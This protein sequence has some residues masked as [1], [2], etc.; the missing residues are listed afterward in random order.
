MKTAKDMTGFKSG[1]LTVLHRDTSR[2]G[3]VRWICQCA[4]GK[5]ASL[6]RDSL[7]NSRRPT[8][9]CGC[10]MR[11][12][13]REANLSPIPERERFM[14]KVDKTSACW[15]WTGKTAKGYGKFWSAQYRETLAHRISYRMFVGDIPA[16]LTLDHLCRNPA[17]VNPEHLE[18]V[19]LAEN[20]RRILREPKARCV[21]GHLFDAA[22]TR[23]TP[24]GERRCRICNS[25]KA[26]QH[27]WRKRGI[28]SNGR[29]RNHASR[30]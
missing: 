8:Q 25:L 26:R 7:T 28:Q 6:T 12:R 5:Q 27:Y 4:C 2:P 11:E 16:G 21:R 1:R 3:R 20:S 29:E 18:P 13:A 10:Y 17:C 19:T 9:S 23:F 30:G 14:A 24:E 15:L 22:N